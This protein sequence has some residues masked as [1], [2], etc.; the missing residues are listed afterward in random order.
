MSMD[1][2]A[3]AAAVAAT[4][5]ESDFDP[6]VDLATL[7]TETVLRLAADSSARITREKARFLHYSREIGKREAWRAEGATSLE[8]WMVERCGVSRSS[9]RTYAHVGEQ[10]EGRPHLTAGL[11]SG[12]LTFAR[13]PPLLRSPPRRTIGIWRIWPRSPRC[14][15]CRASPDGAGC[16]AFMGGNGPRVATRSVSTT[17]ATP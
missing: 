10:L 5:D 13:S 1:T 8:A 14:G 4:P 12:E 7:S 15:S 6:D 17:R 16:A 11:S 9:A 2:I 3:P